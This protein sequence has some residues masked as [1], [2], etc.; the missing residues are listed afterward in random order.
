MSRLRAGGVALL[1]AAFLPSV[2]AF[3]QTEPYHSGQTIQLARNM[4]LRVVTVGLDAFPHVNLT[5]VA[6]VFELQ[7]VP[8]DD[9]PI[10]AL[11]PSK[12][13]ANSGVTLMVG[14]SRVAPKALAHSPKKGSEQEVVMVDELARARD[15][16]RGLWVGFSAQPTKVQWLFDVPKE[17]ANKPTK[18]VLEIL[19]GL[20][21]PPLRVEVVK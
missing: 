16:G 9:G 8:G 17:I 6:E 1:A 15:T 21:R 3:G 5:G 19:V 4:K 10:V 18:L 2:V 20:K 14:D 13:S 11:E 12:D 7:F